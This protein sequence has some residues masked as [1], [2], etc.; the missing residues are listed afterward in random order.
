[1]FLCCCCTA[2]A[3]AAVL[4]TRLP[5]PRGAEGL[6][7]GF[8]AQDLCTS[9]DRCTVATRCYDKFSCLNVE[10]PSV[11]NDC[12]DR[13]LVMSCKYTLDSTIVDG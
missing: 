12:K 2:A 11:Q 8:E 13:A 1:M 7:Q 5:R 10:A 6:K 9:S 4:L 3:A